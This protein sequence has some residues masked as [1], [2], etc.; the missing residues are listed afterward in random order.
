MRLFALPRRHFVFASILSLSITALL[1]PFVQ[2]QTRAG[3]APATQPAAKP[4]PRDQIT[5]KV[6]TLTRQ[7]AT[8]LE[9]RRQVDRAD[10]ALAIYKEAA[11]GGKAI[12]TCDPILKQNQDNIGQIEIE[13]EVA[14]QTG[15]SENARYK[16]LAKR[17]EMMKQANARQIE[18]AKTKIAQSLEEAKFEAAAAHTRLEIATA[19]LEAAKRELIDLIAH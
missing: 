1:N 2:A 9:A 11:A 18:S 17:L 5:A 4:T 15:G 3:D 7:I 19:Q 13:C 6:E 16:S 14:L 12:Q 8:Q 10:S